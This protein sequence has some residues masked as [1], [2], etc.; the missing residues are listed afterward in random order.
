[1]I[2]D[3][4]I[5]TAVTTTA[6]LIWRALLLDHPRLLKLV[7][8]LPLIGGTLSCGF[9]AALWFSLIAVLI[10]NPFLLWRPS[11]PMITKLFI[12]WF[13]LGAGVLFLRN[14]IAVLMEGN[15]VLTEMHRRNHEEE[16]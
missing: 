9:C 4:L 11:L 6:A 7:R 15:G 8:K 10:E 1:M 2:I 3:F 5:V 13:A 16:T 12:G 14:L